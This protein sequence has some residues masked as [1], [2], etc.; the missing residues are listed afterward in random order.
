MESGDR[1]QNVSDEMESGARCQNVSDEIEPNY[2][3]LPQAEV[4]ESE[5]DHK[6]IED[7]GYRKKLYEDMHKTNQLLLETL[8]LVKKKRTKKNKRKEK[9]LKEIRKLQQINEEMKKSGEVMQ[10]I[11]EG[12]YMIQ[13]DLTKK[14]QQAK[15]DL[16]EA[17]LKNWA[18][19]HLTK[20]IPQ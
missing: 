13:E 19:S 5:I 12:Q 6:K 18:T 8:K 20:N 10:K 11:I 2:D 4:Q 15:R 17:R 14:I 9:R 7:V 16:Y 3:S 1:C